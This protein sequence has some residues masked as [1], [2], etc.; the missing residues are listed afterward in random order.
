[1][2]ALGTLDPGGPEVAI[3][4]WPEEV[5]RV[6][7]LRAA[8][9]PRLLLV[10]PRAAAPEPVGDNEDW[11]RRP[12]ADDDLRVRIAALLARAEEGGACQLTVGDGRIHYRGRWA[13]VSETEEDL[14]RTLGEQFGEIVGLPELRGAGGRS[15][16]AASVRVH[17]TRLRRRIGPLGLVV[18]V[19]RGR[20]YVLDDRH[21][22]PPPETG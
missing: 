13:P 2:S 16:S 22:V 18:H 7:R 4:W 14:S 1:V 21:H 19:V 10:A 17:L 6:E 12:V 5:T 3:A 15:L 9:I 8:R 20:G 11:L